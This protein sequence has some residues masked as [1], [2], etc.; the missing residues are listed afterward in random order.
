MQL[1]PSLSASARF[2]P[3]VGAEAR[4]NLV[5]WQGKRVIQKIRVPKSYRNQDLDLWLRRK[6]TREEVELLHQAK[7]AQVDC[8]HVFFAD[9]NRTE[10]FLE[11]IQGQ[12]L[13]DLEVDKAMLR[14]GI[15]GSHRINC[16]EL[17]GMYAARLHKAKIIH[18]DLTTKNVILSQQVGKQRFVLIDFGLSFVSERVEDQAA[19]LHL[20]KQAIKSSNDPA[21]SKSA[22]RSVMRGYAEEAGNRKEEKIHSQMLEIEKRGRYARVD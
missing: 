1:M 22:L 19:D 16:F 14:D 15:S 17:L 20:L 6:R 21:Q 5:M 8:P 12:L 4:I 18:G 3:S 13:R 7:L 2:T 11:Y 9:P 10:I